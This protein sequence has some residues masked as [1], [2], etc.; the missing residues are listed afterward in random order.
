MRKRECKLSWGYD[1]TKSGV[2]FSFLILTLQVFPHR[3]SAC[4]GAPRKATGASGVSVQ[5]MEACWGTFQN[6][7]HWSV[8]FSTPPPHM[9]AHTCVHLD[10]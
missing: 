4:L 7:K 8:Y 3:D 10:T 2:A 6:L 5:R 1:R 9:H